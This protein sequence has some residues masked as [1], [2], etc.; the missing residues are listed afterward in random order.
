MRATLYD[1]NITTGDL[2]CLSTNSWEGHIDNEEGIP[3]EALTTYLG[4][5][6]LI[7]EPNI[8]L[9]TGVHPSLHERYHHQ[10]I[11]SKPAMNNPSPLLHNRRVWLYDRA[12]VSAI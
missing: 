6:K 1:Y 2:N 4:L 10:I 12:N 11:Y 5:H 7:S 9:E 8:S 3:L